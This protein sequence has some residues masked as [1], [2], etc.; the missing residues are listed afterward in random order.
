MARA[1]VEWPWRSVHAPRREGEVHPKENKDEKVDAV[2]DG[3]ALWGDA[4]RG[5]ADASPARHA[6]RRGAAAECGV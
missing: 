5:P 2:A 3:A 1:V 4:G 6:A